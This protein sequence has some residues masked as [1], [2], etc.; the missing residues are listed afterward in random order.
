MKTCK[1]EFFPNSKEGNKTALY[2][3]CTPVLTL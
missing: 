2:Y 1:D 3:D